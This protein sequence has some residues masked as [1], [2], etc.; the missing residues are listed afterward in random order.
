MVT[1]VYHT[2]RKRSGLIPLFLVAGALVS[3]FIASHS[4]TIVM[5]MLFG[6]TVVLA[7]W[8]IIFRIVTA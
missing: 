8:G 5:L 6:L 7:V 4:I 3:F 1:I 2:R